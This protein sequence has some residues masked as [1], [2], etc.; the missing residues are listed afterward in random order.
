MDN[1]VT[2]GRIVD[3]GCCCRYCLSLP[4]HSGAAGSCCCHWYCCRGGQPRR[5][6]PVGRI[7]GN[8]PISK[9]S[10]ALQ[11]GKA[12]KAQQL[13]QD[14]A[15]RGVAAYRAN[16]YAAAVHALEQAKGPDASYNLGNALAKS[17]RYPEAINSLRSCALQLNPANDD[18]RVNRKAVEEAMRKQQQQNSHRSS[19]RNPGSGQ[20]NQ[21]QQKG[22]V[23]TVVRTEP[24]RSKSGAAGWSVF[25]TTKWRAAKHARNQAKQDQNGQQQN[26]QQQ[27]N[28]AQDAQARSAQ[29]DA[30]SQ[31][32]QRDHASEN[33]PSQ[34]PAPTSS[35]EQAQT[36]RAQQ[37]LRQQ[38]NQALAQ[39]QGKGEKKAT[40]S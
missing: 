22:P 27:N 5:M 1:A 6:H 36:E 21:D 13:A 11:Q 39:A 12:A 2:S 25:A 14:P 40:E 38:M 32:D 15:W 28:G 31:Q 37:A 7:G 3:R 29:Q 8:A 23:W 24:K 33:S 4:W 20:N 19:N 34:N 18:A 17:G 10:S 26:G 9:P 35:S 30:K 16:D